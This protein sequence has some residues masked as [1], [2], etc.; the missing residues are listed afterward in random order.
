[1]VYDSTVG[2]SFFVLI[3]FRVIKMKII[4]L[5]VLIT[6][7]AG[8]PFAGNVDLGKTTKNMTGKDYLVISFI[9]MA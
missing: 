2:Y 1:M 7:A 9:T 8:F 3:S 5:A 4:I 6:A